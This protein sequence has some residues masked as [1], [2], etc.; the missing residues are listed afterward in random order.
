MLTLS[1]II[2]LWFPPQVCE[3]YIEM[4]E[5]YMSEEEFNRKCEQSCGVG[6]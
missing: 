4:G 6:W 2:C 1:I 5:Q 3:R